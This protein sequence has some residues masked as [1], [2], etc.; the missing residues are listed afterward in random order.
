MCSATMLLCM[1]DSDVIVV[2][3]IE[4]YV[5][6]HVVASHVKVCHR[7]LLLLLGSSIVYS[8]SL[9]FILHPP[10]THARHP[11]TRCEL[12]VVGALVCIRNCIIQV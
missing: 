10:N 9:L 8:L 3:F 7:E 5:T 1:D 12:G 4:M 6:I 2:E 11:Y